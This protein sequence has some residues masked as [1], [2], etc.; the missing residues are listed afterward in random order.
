[1]KYYERL[2]T[3][4]RK[5]LMSYYCALHSLWEKRQNFSITIDSISWIPKNLLTGTSHA[6]HAFKVLNKYLST[7]QKLKYIKIKSLKQCFT[8][9]VSHFWAT[10][11]CTTFF[12]YYSTGFKLLPVT[13]FPKVNV[14][15]HTVK[16]V[17][18]FSISLPWLKINVE[19][20]K[21]YSAFFIYL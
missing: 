6:Y 21:P 3:N 12:A 8:Y 4:E 2:T 10:H 11:P 5:T 9:S 19:I 18:F 7:V 13:Q 16:V 20:W 15:S 14:N 1:M 17:L